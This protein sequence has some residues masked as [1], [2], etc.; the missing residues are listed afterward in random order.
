[1]DKCIVETYTRLYIPQMDKMDDEIASR[2]DEAMLL[3]G[4]KSQSALARASEV[5]QPTIN[6]ILKGGGKSGPE[7]G[8]LK[9]LASALRVRF[10]WLSD[11][12]GEMSV[13]GYGGTTPDDLIDV[14]SIDD[15][16]RR[17]LIL[18]RQLDERRKR[19]A[20]TFIE[21][22]VNAIKAA[23]FEAQDTPEKRDSRQRTEESKTHYPTGIVGLPADEKRK[24]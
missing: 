15:R 5:P 6:R 22:D 18:F 24:V 12:Q 20:E 9:K 1:M 8:T 10:E 14:T 16:E 13:P 23:A 2:L 4:F 19:K 11:G 17:L 3:R 21:D 7:T